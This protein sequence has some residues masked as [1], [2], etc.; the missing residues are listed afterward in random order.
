MKD[1]FFYHFIYQQFRVV[2][3]IWDIPGGGALTVMAPFYIYSGT[4]IGHVDTN[5]AHL[6]DYRASN[7][8]T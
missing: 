1:T 6:I 5:R 4:A 3:V 2:R 7:S 8:T